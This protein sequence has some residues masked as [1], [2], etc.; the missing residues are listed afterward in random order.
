MNIAIITDSFP[1]MMDG[2]SRSALGYATALH[3]GGYGKVLVVAPRMPKERYDYPFQFYGFSSVGLPYHEYRAG[4]PYMPRLKKL[5][6]ELE[7]EVIH[8]H[9]PFVSM[10]IAAKLRR[11]F[12]VPIVFTQ[13]TKW[14][15]D[16]SC[17]VPVKIL[18]RRIERYAYRNIAK[19]DEVWA[20]SR[21]TGEYLTGRG[22]G[23]GYIVM[24][25]ATD[26]PRRDA[27][28]GRI[29]AISRRY[30]LPEDVPVLICVCRMMMY[31]G[32]GI[33]IDA[34]E[35]LH[36]N[37]FDFRMF[38][39]G[40]G[41]DL[42]KAQTL[43]SDKGLSGL[44]HFTGRI[45]DREELRAYYNR[46]GLFVLPSVYDNAPLTVLEAAACSCPSVVVRGSSTAEIIEDG[47]NGFYCEENPQSV[48]DAVRN[49]FSDR[50]RYNRVSVAAAEQVYMPWDKLIRR[51]HERYA[52]VKR[53][54]GER[55]QDGGHAARGR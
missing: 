47:V 4:L 41:E 3:E 34:L 53:A 23:G 17:A 39:V 26:F 21:G 46:A 50:E 10:T 55:S 25:N 5:F 52:E 8:A 51:A 49:A 20:V 1:P 11:L 13:H 48:A 9:S 29:E 30:A 2:V 31:K 43:V 40:D 7:I 35:L 32:I 54:Y 6:A 36:K 16:I 14:D 19:A 22:F 24:P 37:G 45:T 28:A 15:Y 12:H 44:V 38:F 18:Q 33:T 42:G 27:D